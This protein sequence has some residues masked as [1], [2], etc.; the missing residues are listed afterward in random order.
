MLFSLHALLIFC[1]HF[2]H[3]TSFSLTT[4]C[5]FSLST[6]ACNRLRAFVGS[7]RV[8]RLISACNV[9]VILARKH[10]IFIP[11]VR[12]CCCLSMLNCGKYFP[13]FATLFPD[14]NFI[15]TFSPG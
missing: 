5:N 13:A 3:L 8:G 12:Y 1:F 15:L 9:R 6:A 10:D 7:V 14:L 4:L 11:F 2:S